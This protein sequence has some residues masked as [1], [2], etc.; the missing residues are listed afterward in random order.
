MSRS[1]DMACEQVAEVMPESECTCEYYD[2][3]LVGKTGQ[4]KST[5]G[6]KLLNVDNTDDSKLSLFELSTSLHNCTK[7]L[8]A[9]Q[10]VSSAVPTT[11]A[12]T[13]TE[14]TLPSMEAA[15]SSARKKRFNQADDPEVK[16][17]QVL[18]VTETCTLISNEDLKIRVLD[19]PGFS[20]S[21]TLQRVTGKNLSVFDGNLRIIRWVVR[22]QTQSQLKVRRIV[23]FLPVRGPLEKADGTMQEELKILHHYFGKEIFNSVVIVATNS[24]K[25]TFQELGFDDEDYEETRKVFHQA[26]KVAIGDED[27]GCPPVI[28]IGLNDSPEETLSKIK[29]AH[30]LKDDII[31]PLIFHQDTCARCSVKICCN[32]VS[33][34]IAVVDADGHVIPYAMSKCHPF[35]IPKYDTITKVIGG[36][37]HVL[38]VGMF[39]LLEKYSGIDSWPGFT[40][41]DEV[42]VAC[43]QS[44]G[45]KGCQLV[46][47]EIKLIRNRDKKKVTV[48]PEHSNEL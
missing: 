46:G 21:G 10:T 8:S 7:S 1:N 44:P 18:S 16:G 37:I 5:L 14:T 40:N 11:A 13:P 6:N 23:Y 27:I 15:S 35:F 2:V 48:I 28:Y 22:A 43:N 39:L 41:S 4:G 47:K 19:V 29:S 26:L 34:K 32:E 25:K 20:D 17:D 42:C 31:V 36:V 24:P 12:P 30:V 38:T 45:A 3:V 33:E 9:N